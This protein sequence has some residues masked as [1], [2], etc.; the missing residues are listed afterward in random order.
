MRRIGFC[1]CLAALAAALI[2]AAPAEQPTAPARPT[3]VLRGAPAAKKTQTAQTAKPAAAPAP[4]AAAAS[5][6]GVASAADPGQCRTA[7]DH[8][9]YFCLAGQDADSCPESWTSCRTGCNTPPIQP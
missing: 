8:S 7:C 4:L 3:A 9:Y 2:G 5:P 1:L 6:V